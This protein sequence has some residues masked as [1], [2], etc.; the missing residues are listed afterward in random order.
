LFRRARGDRARLGNGWPPR[1]HPHYRRSHGRV[2]NQHWPRRT[3]RAPE[4][5]LRCDFGFLASLDASGQ[6]PR[7][8]PAK[9]ER[10]SAVAPR[11]SVRRWRARR[12]EIVAEIGPVL[13]FGVVKRALIPKRLFA[14]GLKAGFARGCK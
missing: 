2:K 14:G 5:G 3:I 8:Q 10:R 12:A 1:A 9:S 11:H 7:A 4:S 6:P 13:E